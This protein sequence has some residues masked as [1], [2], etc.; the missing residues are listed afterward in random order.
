M[1]TLADDSRSS[2][3]QLGEGVVSLHDLDSL[4]NCK[5]VTFCPV[6]VI[7]TVGGGGG[8]G[9]AAIR[10]SLLSICGRAVMGVAY[11]VNRM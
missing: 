10:S 11:G 8:G 2:R 3:Q 6:L 5:N 1:F 9:V 4:Q 7:N